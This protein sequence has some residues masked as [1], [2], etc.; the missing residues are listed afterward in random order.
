MALTII[1][2]TSILAEK[3]AALLPEATSDETVE[4]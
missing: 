4:Y 3:E 2:N 1:V